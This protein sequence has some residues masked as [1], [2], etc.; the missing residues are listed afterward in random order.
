MSQLVFNDAASI[1]SQKL[2]VKLTHANVTKRV[3]IIPENFAALK[4]QVKA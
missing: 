4:N 3:R 1:S 2:S